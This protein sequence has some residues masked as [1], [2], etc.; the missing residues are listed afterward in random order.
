MAFTVAF[1]IYKEFLI[2]M[3]AFRFTAVEAMY[4]IGKCTSRSINIIFILKHQIL[5]A[6]KPNCHIT[7]VLLYKWNFQHSFLEDNA[8]CNVKI[9]NLM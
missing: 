9:K 1:N 4:L 7:V 3:K 8:R 5:Y 2:S 6:A